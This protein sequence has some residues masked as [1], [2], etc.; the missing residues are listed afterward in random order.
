MVHKPYTT[1]I[2]IY[3]N[4]LESSETKFMNLPPY[5]FDVTNVAKIRSEQSFTV[6]KKKWPKLF[7]RIVTLLKIR[8]LIFVRNTQWEKAK[9]KDGTLKLSPVTINYNPDYHGWAPK[10]TWLL[11]R[12]TYGRRV[13]SFPGARAKAVWKPP[14]KGQR[15]TM[16]G[17]FEPEG[18]AFFLRQTL[19]VRSLF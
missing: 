13:G 19:S 3:E 12:S 6:I 18:R 9:K 2:K 7:L 1:M 4:T 8:V 11:T 16:V 10:P 17:T 15:Q 5:V 14:G